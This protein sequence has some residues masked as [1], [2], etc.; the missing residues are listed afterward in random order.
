MGAAGCKSSSSLTDLD[1]TARPS[2][3]TTPVGSASEST[4]CGHTLE[5]D[6]ESLDSL[7]VTLSLEREDAELSES[8]AESSREP[9]SSRSFKSPLN[10]RNASAASGSHGSVWAMALTRCST[11]T[12]FDIRT[13]A[14]FPRSC[15]CG[16]SGSGVRSPSAS[17]SAASSEIGGGAASARSG[18]G[19]PAAFSVEPSPF[20]SSLSTW[21]EVAH[22]FGLDGALDE[23]LDES[24]DFASA[25]GSSGFSS[26][27]SSSGFASSDFASFAV[28][29][30]GC[31]GSASSLELESL[32]DFALDDLALDDCALDGLAERDDDESDAA[33]SAG[34]LATFAVCGLAGAWDEAAD[35][36]DAL[37]ADA[38]EADLD[39]SEDATE[40]ARL[41]ADADEDA[42]GD[43][44]RDEPDFDEAFDEEAFDEEAWEEAF[45]D[46]DEDREDADFFD[47]AGESDLRDGASGD[48]D[49]RTGETGGLG[50]GSRGGKGARAVPSSSFG[51]APPRRAPRP[52]GGFPNDLGA[53][54]PGLGWSFHLEKEKMPA[55]DPPCLRRSSG[56]TSRACRTDRSRLRS[57]RSSRSR[58]R[59]GCSRFGRSSRSDRARLRWGGVGGTGDQ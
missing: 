54:P 18:S 45:E 29:S 5:S 20:A 25:A 14:H 43:E 10:H 53:A 3:S 55:A 41:E 30:S 2:S 52:A 31:A 34:F 1:R 6:S 38:D 9:H 23:S 49:L 28:G 15:P 40:L 42:A 4:R 57:G 16:I 27:F 12:A 33:A 17:A 48:G 13:S 51:N 35:E 37:E 11:G 50:S 32:D 7:S 36:L 58:L 21:T 39:E 47:D 8:D 19:D 59:S 24:S 46:E 26:T 44:D 22:E 56:W